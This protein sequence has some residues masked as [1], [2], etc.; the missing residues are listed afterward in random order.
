MPNF[1][2]VC[3]LALR[4]SSTAFVKPNA[5]L[6]SQKYYF[7]R[8]LAYMFHIVKVDVCINKLPTRWLAF[9]LHTLL[10]MAMI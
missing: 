6:I 7:A 8:F 4:A 10:V 5:S 1:Y 2:F 9:C 3:G